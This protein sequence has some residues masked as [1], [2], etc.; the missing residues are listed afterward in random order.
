MT[1]EFNRKIVN[2]CTTCKF[3]VVDWVCEGGAYYYCNFDK[4]FKEIYRADNSYK[5]YGKEDDK[6]MKWLV[7]HSVGTNE[8][9]DKFEIE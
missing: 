5:L 1:E 4:S 2:T 3:C 6:K 8:I 9:C 7:V